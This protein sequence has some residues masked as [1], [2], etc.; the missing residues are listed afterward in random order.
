MHA[1]DHFES[2]NE[3]VGK[4]YYLS[5]SDLVAGNKA[6]TW[7]LNMYV[8]NKWLISVIHVEHIVLL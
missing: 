8:Q 5:R 4:Y 6:Q 2:V 7:N 1:L 3:I